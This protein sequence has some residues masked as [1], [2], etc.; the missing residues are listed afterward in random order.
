MKLRAFFRLLGGLMLATS[1]VNISMNR[2]RFETLNTVNGLKHLQLP[3]P[4]ACPAALGVG[5]I[6]FTLRK[7]EE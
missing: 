6:A 5:C 1:M 3:L 2:E 7:D 4:V